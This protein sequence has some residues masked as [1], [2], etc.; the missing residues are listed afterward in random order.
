[1]NCVTANG[2]LVRFLKSKWID[3][4]MC[5]WKYSRKC[6]L[7]QPLVFDPLRWVDGESLILELRSVFSTDSTRW[8][9]VRDWL[10]CQTTITGQIRSF[11]R[12]INYLSKYK[13]IRIL[14]VFKHKYNM[15]QRDWMIDLMI[16]GKNITIKTLRNNWHFS[17]KYKNNIENTI[18]MWEQL[19]NLE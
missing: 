3:L 7:L 15:K 12:C 16:F 17:S 10:K 19:T 8:Y 13:Y 14:G 6:H 1:M 9:L 5:I 2:S 4:S 11:S 18:N